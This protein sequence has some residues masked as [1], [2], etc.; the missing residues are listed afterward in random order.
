MSQTIEG[1][2]EEVLQHGEELAGHRV[3]VIVLDDGAT[4]ETVASEQRG[5]AR[6]WPVGFFDRT[7]G[8][9]PDLERPPQGEYNERE[10]LS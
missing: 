6:G 3:R 10:P 4:S 5:V 2:W 1:T 8:S 7:V 9:I